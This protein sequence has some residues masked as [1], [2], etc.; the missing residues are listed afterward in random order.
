MHRSGAERVE[1]QLRCEVVEALSPD[2]EAAHV[3]L[4][5]DDVRA[6][7]VSVVAEPLQGERVERCRQDLWDLA[8]IGKRD[9]LCR[10]Q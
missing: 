5:E 6:P 3:C 10:F 9:S 2:D 8:F 4:R 1:E 7:A